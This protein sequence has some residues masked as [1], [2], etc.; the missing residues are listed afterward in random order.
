M[1]NLLLHS[2]SRKRRDHL[3]ICPV[4]GLHQHWR[5]VQSIFVTCIYINISSLH[6]ICTYLRIYIPI[7][8]NMWMIEWSIFFS[9]I[10]N[11]KHTL[12]K[13]KVT[14]LD[15]FEF[16]N[17]FSHQRTFMTE[18]LQPEL[19]K[20]QRHGK[21]SSSWELFLVVISVLDLTLQFLWGGP[22]LKSQLPI[23]VFK[24]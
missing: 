18:Q 22:V 13:L 5:W 9:L 11:E 3:L 10:V 1:V 7:Y 17:I 2:S 14:H 15:C 24:R 4:E 19:P 6:S 12:S 21:K 23:Q 16:C 20:L 8:I